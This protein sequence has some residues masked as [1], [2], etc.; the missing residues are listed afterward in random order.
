MPFQVPQDL[1]YLVRAVGILSGMATGLDPEFNVWHHLAPYA[2]K[3]IYEEGL[4]QGDFWFSELRNYLGTLLALPSRL[5][6]SLDKIERGE[7]VVRSPDVVER[8][9]RMERGVRQLAGSVI[10]IGFLMG[11]VQLVLN[12]FDLPGW[13]L[14]AGAGISLFWLAFLS[15]R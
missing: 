15:G 12:G 4:M 5:N 9:E 11:G 2:E 3:L 6:R 1:I 7:V 10:F 14:L 8:V 13:G